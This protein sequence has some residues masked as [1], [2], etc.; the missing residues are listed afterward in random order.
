MNRHDWDPPP[1]EFQWLNE[2]FEVS[3][4]PMYPPP[5]PVLATLGDETVS[6]P[7]GGITEAPIDLLIQN[8]GY[9]MESVLSKNQPKTMAR[10]LFPRCF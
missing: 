7:G 9:F 6:H 1:P 4:I 2:G 8:A 3:R 10:W 5:K